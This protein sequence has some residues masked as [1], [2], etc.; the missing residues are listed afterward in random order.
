MHPDNKNLEPGL[1]YLLA[2]KVRSKERGSMQIG[3]NLI[4]AYV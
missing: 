2:V 1:E 4:D 3:I